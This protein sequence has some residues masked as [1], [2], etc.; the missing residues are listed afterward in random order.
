MEGIAMKISILDL[1]K[2]PKELHIRVSPNELGLSAD[3]FSF[4]EPVTGVVRFQLVSQ[5][6]LGRGYIETAMETECGRCLTPMRRAVRARVEL[7]YEKRPSVEGSRDEARLPREWDAEA[8]G[9]EYYDEEILDPTDGF[10][11]ILLLE[12]PNYPMC[13]ADCRGLCPHCGADLNRNPCR[14]SAGAADAVVGE[15][16]WKSRLKRIKLT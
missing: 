6:V 11:Q 3:G 4:P 14:C 9:I 12:L 13:K 8:R 10:R 2:A 5:R 7:V 1:R 16:D 15:T